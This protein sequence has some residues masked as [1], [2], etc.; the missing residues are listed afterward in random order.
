MHTRRHERME[1]VIR[2]GFA[3]QRARDRVALQRKVRAVV[4]SAAPVE[5]AEELH[6]FLQRRRDARMQREV[7]EFARGERN[8]FVRK[9]YL[10][11]FMNDI[12]QQLDQQLD[13]RAVEL[14]MD[15]DT[16][17]VARFDEG[18]IARAVH[19][20]ARN[21]VEAMAERG[22]KLTI[23]ARMSGDDLVITVADTGGGIPREVEGRL[24]QSFVSA[25][26]QG[27]TGLGLAIVKKIVDEH[28]GRVE[29]ST[30]SKGS[31]F[32][33]HPPQPRAS[34]PA[35]ANTRPDA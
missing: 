25:G 20:L 14:E 32:V 4:A 35:P 15:V 6:L 8:I 3:C 12:R 30:S 2:R 19:N 16:K 31:S 26:K 21:A 18:R 23:R 22:G 1:Q 27:G 24:F 28:G 29:V 13:G 34:A 7:L 17:V 5:E 10:H 33:L 11:K 9:V